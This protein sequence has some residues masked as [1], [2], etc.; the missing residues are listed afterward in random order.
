MA[1]T[2]QQAYVLSKKFTQDTAEEFGAVKGANCQIKSIVKAN[3]RSTVTFLWKNS[4]DV[5]QESTMIVEDGTPIYVW[6]PD[7]EYEYGDLAIYA[8]AFYRCTT[9]NHDHEFDSTKWSEIGSPDGN[10]DIVETASMLPPIFT[11]ADRKMYYCIDEDIFYLWDGSAWVKRQQSKVQYDVMPTAGLDYVGKVIQYVGNTTP[12]YT[13]GYW[14]SCEEGETQGTY[15]WV[16]VVS[17]TTVDDELSLV[18]ENPVQNKVITEALNAITMPDEIS[19]AEA[20]ADFEA[21][22]GNDVTVNPNL[23]TASSTV[24]DSSDVTIVD[25]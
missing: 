3:G 17:K 20:Q 22:F 9:P 21:V 6:Q 18:S 1:L 7:T 8:S 4:Q 25:P 14:Y 5:T 13:K 12:T 11:A 24:F 2:G 19:S 10:Y 23:L 16:A 15:E